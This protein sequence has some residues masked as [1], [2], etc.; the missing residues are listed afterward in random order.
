MT[1]SPFAFIGLVSISLMACHKQTEAPKP[2]AEAVKKAI[3]VREAADKQ[4]AA[5]NEAALKAAADKKID[6]PVPASPP[7]PAVPAPTPP[8]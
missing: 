4:V 6:V 1:F 3:E 7:A 2:D 5:A 8:K